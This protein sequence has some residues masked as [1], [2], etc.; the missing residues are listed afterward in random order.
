MG[1]NLQIKHCDGSYYIFNLSRNNHVISDYFY[2][3]YNEYTRE[4]L[5]KILYN[6]KKKKEEYTDDDDGDY[7]KAIE[8][9]SKLINCCNSH[10]IS[11]C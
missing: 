10:D 11:Y 7:Y 4:E 1:R 2:E 8:I 3:D 9:V 5:I 6:K